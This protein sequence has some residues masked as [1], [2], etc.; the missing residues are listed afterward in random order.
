MS[1]G[2]GSGTTF[3]GNCGAVNT[4]TPLGDPVGMPGDPQF[5]SLSPDDFHL[6]TGNA[7]N[8]ACCTNKLD[9]GPA[10]DLDGNPRPKGAKFDIGAYEVE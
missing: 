3:S 9:T 4:V 8:Q 5:T 2:L 6:D 7:K 1:G 10:I